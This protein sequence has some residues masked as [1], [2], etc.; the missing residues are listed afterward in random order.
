[1]FCTP[2]P[3][4]KSLRSRELPHSSVDP[5]SRSSA[6]SMK[7]GQTGSSSPSSSSSIDAHRID[8]CEGQTSR[9]LGDS[10]SPP[11]LRAIRPRSF[12]DSGGC[13]ESGRYFECKSR[14]VVRYSGRKKGVT[15]SRV[16]GRDSRRWKMQ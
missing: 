16:V 8:P 15:Q 11:C 3:R 6:W 14:P 5:V 1:M 12:M 13:Q 10:S 2:T 7:R 9:A 4:R